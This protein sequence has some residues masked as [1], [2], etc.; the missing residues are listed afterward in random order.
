LRKAQKDEEHCAKKV[1]FMAKQLDDLEK[2]RI[3]SSKYKTV[4]TISKNR[5]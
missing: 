2:C 5:F 4:N 1:E 3:V